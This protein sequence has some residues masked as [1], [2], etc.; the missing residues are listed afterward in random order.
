SGAASFS[1]LSIAGSGSYTLGFAASGLTAAA[2]N[3]I[4]VT[5]PGGGGGPVSISAISRDGGS[6]AG[7]VVVQITG[8]GFGASD[9]VKFGSAT[10]TNVQLVNATPLQ[11]TVPPAAATPS[12]DGL[13]VTVSVNH[14]G[15]VATLSNAFTYYPGATTTFASADFEDG[16]IG[17][18]STI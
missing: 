14:G 6:S 5:Q 12:R 11:V 8:S 18:F 7:G 4:S 2:S 16:T 3:A 17:P 10:A 15:T 1:N 13:A 9:V